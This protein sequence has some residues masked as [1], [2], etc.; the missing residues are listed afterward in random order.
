MLIYG[1]KVTTYADSPDVVMYSRYGRYSGQPYEEMM[2]FVRAGTY[3]FEPGDPQ[4]VE[5]PDRDGRWMMSHCEHFLGN[6]D[7]V[8]TGMHYFDIPLSKHAVLLTEEEYYRAVPLF[9]QEKEQKKKQAF[10]RLAEMQQQ[11]RDKRA[12]L[13][14]RLGLNENEVELLM[15]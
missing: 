12:A 5:L 13:L 3:G 14:S 9:E 15:S 1:R 8:D 7:F 6:P 11:R 2:I 4:E 10:M